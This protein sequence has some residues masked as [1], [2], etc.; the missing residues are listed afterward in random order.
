[1]VENSVL[2]LDMGMHEFKDFPFLR[3][4]LPGGTTLHG[5]QI[6]QLLPSSIAPRAHFFGTLTTGQASP[7]RLT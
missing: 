3:E 7:E 2:A 1:M 6:M 4:C 5:L